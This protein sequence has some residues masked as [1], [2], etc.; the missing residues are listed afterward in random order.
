MCGSAGPRRL[1]QEA[2]ECENRSQTNL[3]ETLILDHFRTLGLVGTPRV[4]RT[5]SEG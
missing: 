3:P 1:L 4:K 2:A 5:K